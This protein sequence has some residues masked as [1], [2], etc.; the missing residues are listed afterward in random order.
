MGLESRGGC[1]KSQISKTNPKRIYRHIS[2]SDPTLGLQKNAQ[3]SPR[4]WAGLL[5]RLSFQPL[6]GGVASGAG[7]ERRPDAAGSPSRARRVWGGGAA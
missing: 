1:S 5:P 4:W 6:G 2:N 7:G 3:H